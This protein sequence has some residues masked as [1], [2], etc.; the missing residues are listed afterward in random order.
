MA[1]TI[2][3]LPRARLARWALNLLDEIG[4]LTLWR[5]NI[6]IKLICLLRC[7][8]SFGFGITTIILVPFFEALGIV[9]KRIGLF[10]SMTLGGDGVMS[11]PL[12][13]IADTVGRRNILA[14]GA[15]LMIVSG[16]V[17]AFADNFWLL[18]AAA[19]LGVI[20]PSGSDIGPFRPVEE[21][22]VAH[23]TRLADRASIYTW[24]N[25]LSQATGSLG[26]NSGWLTTWLVQSGEWTRLDAYRLI[27]LVYAVLGVVQLVMSLML[28]KDCE[29]NLSQAS[30]GQHRP[31][32]E[33]G[34]TG[35]RGL[36]PKLR[37][38]S[39]IIL[40]QVGLLYILDQFASGLVP[41]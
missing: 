10:M 28:T 34:N 8:R 17:F 21:S 13:L 18:L 20:T 7:V 11:I 2:E 41:L 1:P 14:V 15:L 33:N 37:R 31:E 19:V 5:S 29:A 35:I 3:D 12:G 30:E 32:S 6:N 9:D 23:L 25:L 26:L 22:T 27:F 4:L 24:Y 16:V 40:F 36:L 38:K 39:M